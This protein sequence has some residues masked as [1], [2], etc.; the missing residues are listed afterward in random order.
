M[1]RFANGVRLTI[2]PTKLRANE[3]L[4]RED[5]GRGRLGLPNDHPLAIW[6]SPAVVLSGTKAMD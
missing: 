6:T 4:V 5:I 2:K 3:V 1:V